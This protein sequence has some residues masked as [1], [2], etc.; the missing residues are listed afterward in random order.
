MP[1]LT[2]G[3]PAFVAQ[4]APDVTGWGPYQFP[5]IERLADGSLHIT[6]HLHADSAT[7]YGSTNGHAVSRDEGRT[8]QRVDAPASPGGLPLPNGDRI[9]ADCAKAVPVAGLDLPPAIASRHSS[10]EDFAYFGADALPPELAKAWPILRL[11]QGGS[12]WEREWATVVFK[13]AADVRTVTENLL[14]VPFFEHNRMHVARD[15]ALL[16][17][18]YQM[19]QFGGRRGNVIKRGFL[20]VVVESLDF[21]RTWREIGSIPYWSDAAS[22]RHW[23][24]R[25]GFSEPQIVELPDGSLFALLRSEDG[26]GG[27]DLAPIYSARS[28]D[29]GVT[30]SQPRVFDDRGVWPQL[31]T[32]KSGVTLASY[33]RPGLFLR[34][35]SDPAGARWAPRVVLVEPG[36]DTPHKNTRTCAYSGLI[37]LS[38]TRALVVHS[39]FQYPDAQG[40][41]CKTLLTRTIDVA[42]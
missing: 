12:T 33:G 13:E 3:Q 39:D 19:P 2:L 9:L 11:K 31:L 1:T 35:T 23:D 8:W 40:R 17:T 15:G 42:V 20:T 28:L 37:A 6:F 10:Y 7:A 5:W 29:R 16:A 32:L 38:A 14:V 36:S 18:L 30:W 34:A 41:P 26:N 25:D 22:D 24:A 21:G 27:N 4:A